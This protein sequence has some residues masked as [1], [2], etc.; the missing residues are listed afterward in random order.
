MDLLKDNSIRSHK[1]WLTAGKP[2][3]DSVAEQR[4]EDML[5][6]KHAIGVEQQRERP[7]LQTTY[8][9]LYFRSLAANF[10]N[11]GELNLIINAV[12]VSK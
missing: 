10:G 8:M 6:Y 11:V 5:A 9:Q 4:R 2:H 1:I 3:C 12:K 7:A